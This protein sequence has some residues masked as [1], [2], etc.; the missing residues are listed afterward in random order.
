MHIGKYDTIIHS[1][2]DWAINRYR[3]KYDIDLS[4]IDLRIDETPYYNNGEPDTDMDPRESAGSWTD[5]G[6]VHI[7][8]NIDEV[9]KY[10][11]VTSSVDEFNK[12]I[13]GHELAHEIYRN[14]ADKFFIDEILKQAKDEN[15]HTIYLDHVPQHK[16]KEEMFC[17]YMGKSILNNTKRISF[18]D[19]QNEVYESLV[20]E[21][22]KHVP[23]HKNSKGEKAPWCIVSH[24]TN[25][26]LSSH[27]TKKEAEEHLKHMK[28]FK[29]KF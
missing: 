9:M 12:Q 8:P 5:K 21:F 18:S 19:L 24:E 23:G 16:L 6:F 20:L 28:M 3:Q 27:K 10:Y 25:K 14:I 4:Y 11:G 1:N 22:I 26:I 13:I 7:N 29:N 2:F 17:E 15:F